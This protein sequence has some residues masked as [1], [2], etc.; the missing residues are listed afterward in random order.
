MSAT[1]CTWKLSFSLDFRSQATCDPSQYWSSSLLGSHVDPA[2]VTIACLI[3]SV[4]PRRIDWSSGLSIEWG[5]LRRYPLSPSVRR[6][7]FTIAISSISFLK[8]SIDYKTSILSNVIND[9]KNLVFSMKTCGRMN[10]FYLNYIHIDN[11][12]CI[13][14]FD[15]FQKQCLCWCLNSTSWYLYWYRS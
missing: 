8:N 7:S 3:I 6:E 4:C 13:V 10:D 11:C 1:S 9:R 12:W 14:T 5:T 2:Y 15:V